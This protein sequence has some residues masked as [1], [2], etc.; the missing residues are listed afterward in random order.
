[1]PKTKS[2]QIDQYDCRVVDRLI[3]FVTFPSLSRKR[4]GE[5]NESFIYLSWRFLKKLFLN[6]TPLWLMFHHFPI[7][8]PTPTLH[9]YSL[10]LQSCFF[11][12]PPPP[13]LVKFWAFVA[14]NNYWPTVIKI[15]HFI[16]FVEH[17]IHAQKVA[18]FNFDTYM[19]KHIC[20]RKWDDQK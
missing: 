12:P 8:L 16:K 15:V 3:W 11:L 17:V 10:R 5:G 13:H 1:M 19:K 2:E 4:L 18:W 14:H 20:T 9:T 7:T 6:P